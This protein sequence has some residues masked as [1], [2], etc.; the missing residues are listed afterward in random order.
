MWVYASRGA[1]S[2][3]I[4]EGL[5]T[6]VSPK[7]PTRWPSRRGFGG[8]TDAVR[9]AAAP[10]ATPALIRRFRST[11]RWSSASSRFAAARPIAANWACTGGL[12]RRLKCRVFTSR[13]S[14][15]ACGANARPAFA[16]C[17]NPATEDLSA[18]W[19]YR[20]ELFNRACAA[21]SDTPLA[22]RQRLID[23]RTASCAPQLRRGFSVFDDDLPGDYVNIERVEL[24]HPTPTARS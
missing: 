5:R 13:T 6:S 8:S 2:C 24:K 18:A 19:V 23:A 17:G 16:P 22:T 11:R 4:S 10:S 12:A 15:T 21:G 7:R 14:S 3:A 9:T 20:A 1:Q